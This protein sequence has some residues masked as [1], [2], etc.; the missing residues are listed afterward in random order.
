MNE[1]SMRQG[2]LRWLYRYFGIWWNRRANKVTT[3]IA[4]SVTYFACLFTIPYILGI[5]PDDLNQWGDYFAGFAAP[6]ALGWFVWTLVMQRKE[7]AVQRKELK[8]TRRENSRANESRESQL[9]LEQIN[10]Y[11][12]RFDE[13]TLQIIRGIGKLK[14]ADANQTDLVACLEGRK[15]TTAFH[16]RRDISTEAKV[17]INEIPNIGSPNT[18]EF[19]ISVFKPCDLFKQIH[20][21]YLKKA[22]RTNNVFA[23]DP[24]YGNCKAIS[25]ELI[26]ETN[27]RLIRREQ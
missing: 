7:L 16:G 14:L 6:V 17:L 21:E 19:V 15:D 13:I 20:D 10:S 8:L 9:F 1:K 26:I 27:K 12:A 22:N 24:K 25:L 18:T 5:A 4:V 23:I 11:H 3:M 2:A